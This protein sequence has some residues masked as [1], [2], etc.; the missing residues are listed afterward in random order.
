MAIIANHE[1]ERKP[2][3]LTER[4]LEMLEEAMEYYAERNLPEQAE[5]MRSQF[6]KTARL[7]ETMP[8][9]GTIYEGWM[10]KFPLKKFPYLIYYREHSDYTSIRGIWHT[11]RGT[12][13]EDT[14]EQ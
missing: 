12:G 6:F 3:R 14:E 8:G 13:F 1:I 7:L 9:I 11:S 10:R 4:C 5:K 2:V